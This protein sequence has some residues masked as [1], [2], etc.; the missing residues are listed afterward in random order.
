MREMMGLAGTQALGAGKT[1]ANQVECC[2][3]HRWNRCGAS[4]PL[5]KGRSHAELFQAGKINADTNVLKTGGS[6]W[7]WCGAL[8]A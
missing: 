6:G 7:V 4:A 1:L 5:S 3:A 8:G 2:L